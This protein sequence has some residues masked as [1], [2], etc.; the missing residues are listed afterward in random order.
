[1]AKLLNSTRRAMAKF[2]NSSLITH[3]F[4]D[5]QAKPCKKQE[6]RKGRAEVDELQ[7]I[8][9]LKI[10]AKKNVNNTLLSGKTCVGAEGVEPYLEKGW[11][12]IISAALR[13]L[14]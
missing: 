2:I 5:C 6:A 8:S 7:L 11:L 1:M 13:V 9:Q 14:L 10:I 3:E 4:T 12:N